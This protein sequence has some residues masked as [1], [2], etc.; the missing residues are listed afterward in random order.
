MTQIAMTSK[1]DVFDRVA[2]V[3]EGQLQTSLFTVKEVQFHVE[4]EKVSVGY[5]V[6]QVGNTTF[7]F[8]EKEHHLFSVDQLTALRVE[9]E[10]LLDGAS[11]FLENTLPDVFSKMEKT[12]TVI[13]GLIRQFGDVKH[14]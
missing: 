10:N 5:F 4:A 7:A 11:W 14:A 2:V 6:F 8:V 3:K 1:Y 12:L 9:L 13:D